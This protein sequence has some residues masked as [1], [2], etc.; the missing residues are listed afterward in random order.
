M[1]LLGRNVARSATNS[2]ETNFIVSAMHLAYLTTVT[3]EETVPDL[4]DS[5]N[6]LAS[7]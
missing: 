6:G 4:P 5:Y 7:V 2:V 1:R 3:T